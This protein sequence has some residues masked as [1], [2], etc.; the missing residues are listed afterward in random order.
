[1]T[2]QFPWKRFWCRRE[3]SF[4]L[5]DRGFLADPEGKHGDI[6]N[7]QLTTLDQLQTVSLLS[8]AGEPGVGKAGASRPTLMRF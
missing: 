7:P 2:G 1:M 5:G 8:V 3:A 6:L 4:S